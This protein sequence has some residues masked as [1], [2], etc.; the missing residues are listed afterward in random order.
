MVRRSPACAF[1]VSV[2]GVPRS[3]PS[4]RRATLK[5]AAA[6]K[7]LRV[8]VGKMAARIDRCL[9]RMRRLINVLEY[10]VLLNIPNP[11]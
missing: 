7:E 5:S 4:A 11:I 8:G 3:P 9:L 6:A 2:G 1:D 10:I